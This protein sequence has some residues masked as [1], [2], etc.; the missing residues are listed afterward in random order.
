[1][2]ETLVHPELDQI[3]FR[4]ESSLISEGRLQIELQFPYVRGHWLGAPEDW[5][6]PSKHSTMLASQGGE[7]ADLRREVDDTTYHCAITYNR[8]AALVR[9]SEHRYLLELQ[10][11][12]ALEC[13]VTFSESPVAPD[14]PDVCATQG[15][16]AAHWESYWRG[17]AMVDLSESEDPRWR[18]FEN[19]IVLSQYVTAVNCVGALPPQESGLVMNTWYGKFHLEMHYWHDAH[20]ALW[21]RLP[22]M[23]R[24]M[25]YYRDILP[26]QAK[27]RAVKATAVRA[28]PRWSALRGANRPTI[29]TRSWCGSSRIRSTT[30]S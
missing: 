16:T 19:R 14:L 6:S 10:G 18:E 20:F 12:H 29:S 13:T 3:A 26:P 22:L 5:G 27:L 8:G 1:M 28:G 24:S 15:A 17:G 9:D 2:V 23:M 21:G 4:I 30:P 11:P 25:G 7:R